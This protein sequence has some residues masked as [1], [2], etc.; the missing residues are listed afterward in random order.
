MISEE[1]PAGEFEA[2]LIQSYGDGRFRVAG[3]IY[4]GSI[5]VAADQTRPWP[6]S[7]AV[8]I[9]ADSL[10]AAFS[11][12][13]DILLIGCGPDFTPPPDGL[14]DV[15]RE[16]GMVLEW[17]DTGGACRTFNVLLAEERPVIAALIAVE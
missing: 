5:V 10:S 17:M 9:T 2:Q 15:V 3:E 6:V 1:T 16:A 11:S 13:A 14:R 7:E 4:E 12:D 8:A